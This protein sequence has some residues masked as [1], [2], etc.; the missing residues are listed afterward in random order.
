MDTIINRLSLLFGSIQR[1]KATQ[2]QSPMV[3]KSR[4]MHCGRGVVPRLMPPLFLDGTISRDL[5]LAVPSFAP[6]RVASLQLEFNDNLT[7]FHLFQQCLVLR[8]TNGQTCHSTSTFA[9]FRR[10]VSA[11]MQLFG[12]FRRFSSSNHVDSDWAP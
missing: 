10:A 7:V 1:P 11:N 9:P 5:W 4:L 8:K 2:A 12:G 6:E 3:S